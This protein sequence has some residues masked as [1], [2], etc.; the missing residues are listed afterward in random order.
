MPGRGGRKRSFWSS[1]PFV[2]LSNKALHY[3][4]ASL[5]I[6]GSFSEEALITLII[7]VGF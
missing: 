1:G 7:L 3:T 4:P 2:I 6:R 5:A